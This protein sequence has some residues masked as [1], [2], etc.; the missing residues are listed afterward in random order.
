MDIYICSEILNIRGNE[1]QQ[2][3]DIGYLLEGIYRKRI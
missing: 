1:K 3:Q 2:I